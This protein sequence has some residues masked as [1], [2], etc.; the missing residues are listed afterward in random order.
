MDLN[1]VM[2]LSI[3]MEKS[4]NFYQQLGLKL[5]V[6]SNPHYA[7]FECPRGNTTF[8]IHLS[9]GPVLSGNIVLYFEVEKLDDRVTELKDMGVQFQTDPED[10]P[11]LWREAELLDPD[12][13]KLILFYAGENR[14][15]PPWRLKHV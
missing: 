12:G 14:K 2:I 1:Q 10:K 11:W 13:N 7:R 6:K 3:D 9:D 4:I 15:Y 8:S 5:I